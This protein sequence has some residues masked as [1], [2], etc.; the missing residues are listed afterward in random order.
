MKTVVITGST[1][2]IGKLLVKEF[3]KLGCRIFAGYRN[4]AHRAELE[5]VSLDVIPFYIDMSKK[6]TVNEA[7]K[8][9]LANLDEFEN[10]SALI[11]A[12]GAVVAG[13]MECLSVDKIREQFEVNTFSHLQLT[14]G[15]I[16]KIQG[17]KIIN[18][19]SVASFGIFPFIGPYC[20]SKRSLDILFNSL[21]LEC[22]ADIKVVSV[23]PGVVKTPLWDKSIE[24]NN[25][26]FSG[27]EKYKKEFEF[28]AKNAKRNNNRGLEAQEVVDLIVKIEKMEK[29]KASYTI[30]LDAKGAEVLSHLPQGLINFIVK[31]SLT[32]RM[33]KLN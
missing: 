32:K 15:L 19:S 30:G 11:N 5:S 29:P 4:E 24:N 2:G 28:L 9:I 14:Q 16:S 8:F 21:Q 22:G 20:A 1:S 27:N 12:A 33:N 26:A 6:E 10:I 23:K 7:T 18:I 17:G 31:K 13:A 25:E 3:A